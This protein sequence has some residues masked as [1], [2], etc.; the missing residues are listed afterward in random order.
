MRLRSTLQRKTSRRH[1][2]HLGECQ[3]QSLPYLFRR[4]VVACFQGPVQLLA[5]T[6]DLPKK[7][8]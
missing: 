8:G 5:Q 2:I 7:K 3:A 6:V 1:L 4:V